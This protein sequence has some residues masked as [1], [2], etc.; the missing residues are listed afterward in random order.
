ML[1]SVQ[2]WSK[3]KFFTPGSCVV[4]SQRP[5]TDIFHVFACGHGPR[6]VMCS[7]GVVQRPTPEPHT[8]ARIFWAH[9]TQTF[10]I[11]YGLTLPIQNYLKN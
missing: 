6:L 5:I 8:G 4:V 7:T 2:K 9:S 10:Y 3:D 11:D 1:K